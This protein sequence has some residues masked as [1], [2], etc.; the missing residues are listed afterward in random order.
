ME[1]T[2]TCAGDIPEPRLKIKVDEKLEKY[3]CGMHT[4][5]IQKYQQSVTC[6]KG[7]RI[8]ADEEKQDRQGYA[9]RMEFRV[10]GKILDRVRV[11]EY[12][13]RVL[14]DNNVDLV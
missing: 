4:K 5:H 2:D 13:G 9:E 7:R 14:A 10:S 1:F 3:K 11:F 12:L 8:R 6:E